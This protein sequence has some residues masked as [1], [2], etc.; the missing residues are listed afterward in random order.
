[1][2]FHPRPA[3]SAPPPSGP[4]HEW[5]LQAEAAAQL[6]A[7]DPGASPAQLAERFLSW[8]RPRG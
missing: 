5:P 8:A 3:P 4:H 2:V 7:L 1:M 6:A